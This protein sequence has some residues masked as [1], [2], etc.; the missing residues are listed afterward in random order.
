[1]VG[2]AL[3]EYAKPIFRACE[4]RL[5]HFAKGTNV[6]TESAEQLP[7][8]RRSF[9][10]TSRMEQ[11]CCVCCVSWSSPPEINAKNASETRPDSRSNAC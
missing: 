2:V 10:E 3:A 11:V 1:M 4:R 5:R 9:G 6:P 7:L 8:I